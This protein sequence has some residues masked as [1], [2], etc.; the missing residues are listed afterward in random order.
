MKK[1]ATVWSNNY[2]EGRGTLAVLFCCRLELLFSPENGGGDNIEE[3]GG[4]S[5]SEKFEVL[6]KRLWS[7]LKRQQNCDFILGRKWQGTSAP[8]HL[9]GVWMLWVLAALPDLWCDTG[10]LKEKKRQRCCQ[11]TPLYWRP[12]SKQPEKLGLLH[13]QLLTALK[14]FCCFVTNFTQLVPRWF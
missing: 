13:V 10:E 11:V 1:P 8:R 9:S 4:K 5:S 12:K 3:V 14:R 7:I 6:A 2:R